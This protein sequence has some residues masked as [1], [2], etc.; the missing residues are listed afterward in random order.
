M[1]YK[2]NFCVPF[3]RETIRECNSADGVS[4]ITLIHVKINVKSEK[5]MF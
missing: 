3:I 1:Q 5:T 4:P 2:S